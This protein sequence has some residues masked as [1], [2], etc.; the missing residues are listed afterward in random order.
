MGKAVYLGK[1]R[2]WWC[3]HCNLPLLDPVCSLCGKKARKVQMTPPGEVRIGF[4]GDL[5]IL[6]DAIEKQFGCRLSRNLVLFNRVP[7]FDRMD[8]V[9]IN[10]WV[11]GNLRYDLQKK[12]FFISLRMMGAEFLNSCATR[13]IVVA[14]SGA[15]D[16]ILHGKNLM[17]P[18]VLEV[19][20]NITAGDEIIVRD[21]A[22]MAI[23]TGI[24]KMSTEDM[25]TAQRGMAVKIRHSGHVEFPQKDEKKIEDV[26]TANENH[27]KK[28][29][30][31]GANFIRE[32]SKTYDLPVAVSFSGGKDSLVTLLLAIKSGVEFNT[33]F[34][35]TGIEFSETVNYVTEVEEKYHLKIDKISAGNAFWKNLEFFGPPGRD[36]RWC[37]KVTKLGPTTR[38]IIE[39]YPSGL[40][41]LIGQ[42]RYESEGRMHKGNLWKNDWVP[43]QL[44][45][46]PIQNWT[47]LEV[48]LYTLWKNAPVNPWYRRGLTRIGCYL[49][50]SS[51]LADFKIERY[52][53]NRISKWL[54]F[55]NVFAKNNKIDEKWTE[56]S[57]RWK[58]PPRW[59]GG[60][61]VHREPLKL[62]FEGERWKT[63]K[64]NRKIEKE[65]ISN[66]L[67]MLPPGTWKWDK[68]LE[69]LRKFET[70]ATS[71]IIRA[72][73]C[74][75]CGI[76]VGRC[77]TMALSLDENGK[78]RVN[79]E[80]CMH[81]LECLGKCPAEEFQ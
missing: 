20:N 39:K 17:V 28:I 72:V 69:I 43:N 73:E 52:H 80:K 5:K 75:G 56:S 38:Y 32:L 76:C 24:A 51:D 47:S 27:L 78:V 14:D 11:V 37:C 22:G 54:E 67:F 36:Y 31:T 34:L 60:F 58:N 64:F 4:E 57:W 3:D 81:C 71:L 29:E 61:K 55:L 40:L 74:V 9:I 16:P 50:P 6:N 70:E 35:D 49:C 66:M 68:N 26:I 33:F 41:T 59:A 1:L 2:L 8:E 13:G 12:D 77:P 23:A 30:N 42:R 18:G 46:S 15:V 53:S 25:K 7:H 19:S 10:G 45:A 21:T 44:S 63:V 65:K 79:E 62:K 48:W